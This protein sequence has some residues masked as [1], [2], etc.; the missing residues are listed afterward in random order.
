MFFKSTRPKAATA[1]E[2]RPSADNVSA[3]I[4][5]GQSPAMAGSEGQDRAPR[6]DN[7]DA[8]SARSTEATAAASGGAPRGS[9]QPPEELKRR[10]VVARRASMHFGQIV[11]VLMRS[12]QL[13]RM[14]LEDVERVV[15]PA[16]ATG[17]FLVA[18]AQSAANG[19]TA[20]IGVVLWAS[21]SDDVDRRLSSALER[22]L[23][24]ATN[25]WTSGKNA[26]LVAAAGE[27][28]VVG[29]M[30]ERLQTTALKDRPLKAV[31]RDSSGQPS[32][33]VWP[34]A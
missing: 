12:D 29:S 24:L 18:E 34:A 27:S 8:E 32:L 11:S 10:A 20:P 14:T 9:K 4:G 6:P 25:E 1:P 23:R 16:V 13:K 2:A 15:V 5:D 22:P 31:S 28:R 26:W 30:L 17:Q 33:K 21:V 7:V 3:P 19:L